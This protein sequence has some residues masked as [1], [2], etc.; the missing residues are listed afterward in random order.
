VSGV[1][2]EEVGFQVERGRADH[3]EF[4]REHAHPGQVGDDR[5]LQ[6]RDLGRVHVGLEPVPVDF[7]VSGRGV[8]ADG[9]RLLQVRRR[10]GALGVAVRLD[11]WRQPAPAAHGDGV[12]L[13]G[14][15]RQRE[16]RPGLRPDAGPQ[17]VRHAVPADQEEADAAEGSVNLGGD[18]GAA[19]RIA[20]EP[21]REVD[22]G[23]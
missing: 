16:E 9:E 5:G 19:R 4:V 1:A 6:R 10:R 17:L 3:Q 20:A 15:R 23:N 7:G 14:L 22:D 12:A 2:G 21:G 13:L 8:G 11:A 18:G